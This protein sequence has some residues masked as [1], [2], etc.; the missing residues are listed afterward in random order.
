MFEHQSCLQHLLTPFHYT[1]MGHY[2]QELADVF[3]TS[4]QFA[5]TRQEVASDGDFMTLELC[6]EP[7]LLKNFDGQLRAF[8][9][10][11]PH[12]HCMLTNEPAGNA[13]GLFCQYHGWEFKQD[14]CTGKIPE[15]KA[16]R[17]W[18]RDNSQLTSLALEVCGDLVFVCLEPDATPSLREWLTPFYDDLESAFRAPLWRMA[19]VW[20]FDCEC[21][22]K[23]PTENTL[24]SYHVATVHPKWLGD[25]LPNERMSEHQLNDRYTTLR[26]DCDSPMEEK[27]ARIGRYL[28]GEVDH[29]YRHW[30]IHP[31]IA[32][33]L[34]DTFNYLATCQ[35]TSPTT[36]RVRTRM[37]ALHGSKKNPYARLL[38]YL[39][40]R[41][42]RR[43]MRAVFNEDR[44]IFDAQQKGIQ[45]S[46]HRGVIGTREERIHIFQRFLCNRMNLE[47]TPHPDNIRAKEEFQD[48]CSSSRD[49]LQSGRQS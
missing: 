17:P 20:D 30:H 42:G 24:E 14:G 48:P 23:I 27:Q 8:L 2:Q 45:S 6:G 21:N 39:A 26:Y 47:V 15:A 16:F 19:E 38:R 41:V 9:N 13:S 34:T 43:T 33:C 44:A 7:V 5:C 31:N 1:D 10:V 29:S 46:P 40:W 12:R 4:W 22:W 28:G 37:F 32:F 18:D 35:P 11:C 25:Q 49:L 36:C 3:R